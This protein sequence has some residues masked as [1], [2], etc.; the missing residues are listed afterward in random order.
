MHSF[1]VLL[2]C[3]TAAAVTPGNADL[4]EE[5]GVLVSREGEVRAISALWTVVVVVHPPRK[6]EFNAWINHLEADL[7]VLKA[8][9]QAG[10]DDLKNWAERV[11]FMKQNLNEFRAIE[12]SMGLPASRARRSPLDFIGSLSNALFGTATEAQIDVLTAALA[13]SQQRIDALTHRG[14]DMVSV[15]NQT[16]RYL[17]ENRMDIQTLQNASKELSTRVQTNLQRAQGVERSIDMIHIRHHVDVVLDGVDRAIHLYLH[18][19]GLFHR[20]RF[21]LERGFLTDEIL[22]QS[23]LYDVLRKI[24]EY[25]H[26]VAPLRWHYQHLT[27]KPLH[28]FG[29]QRTFIAVIPG[30]TLE[31]Y[32]HFHLSYFPIQ[33]GNGHLRQLSGAQDVVLDSVSSASFLPDV[34]I[35][36]QPKVCRVTKERLT[37]TCE[38]NLLTGRRPEGCNAVVTSRQGVTSQVYRETDHLSSIVMV[39]YQPTETTLRCTEE[40]PVVQTYSGLVRIMVRTGCVLEAKGWRVRG[41]D[42]GHSSVNVRTPDYIQLPS[43]NLTFPSRVEDTLKEQLRFTDR[44]DIPLLTLA[45]FDSFQPNIQ[46]WTPIKLGT[47]IGGPSLFIVIVLTVSLII[48][49]KCGCC[50]RTGTC[51][52]RA[53]GES[54]PTLPS[55]TPPAPGHSRSYHQTNYNMMPHLSNDNPEMIPLTDRKAIM[56]PPLAIVPVNDDMPVVAELAASNPIVHAPAD[57]ERYPYRA[58][59]AALYSPQGFNSAAIARHTIE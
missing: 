21:E 28:S 53:I 59:A 46:P 58:L 3:L 1:C 38:S 15:M 44:V 6:P 57:S 7:A 52:L 32:I 45:D 35:G 13:E 22:P 27:V 29:D 30:L 43:F 34:C 2:L 47:I 18:Q 17:K 51:C 39:A 41:V 49:V 42:I 50:R 19:M 55:Y 9:G 4:F 5:E 12:E 20:Q 40:R 26:E 24:T 56:P 11:I 25:K 16:R 37:A 8:K 54:Q 23:Y 14:S 33:L 48:C 10:A 31:K 36:S